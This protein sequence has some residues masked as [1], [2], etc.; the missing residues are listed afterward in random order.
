LNYTKRVGEERRYK[1]T[2]SREE[3][4]TSVSFFFLGE[5]NFVLFVAVSLKKKN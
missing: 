2:L 3:V 4:I 1:R 5:G